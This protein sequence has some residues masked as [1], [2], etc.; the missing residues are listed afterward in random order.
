LQREDLNPVEEAMAYQ[1]L[2][3]DFQLTQESIA[4]KV[5]KSRAAVA[6]SLRLLDL[7]PEVREWLAGGRLSVGHAKVLLGVKDG[8]EQNFLANQILRQ[9]LTVRET[10]KLVTRHLQA[11]ENPASPPGKTPGSP[12]TLPPAL[13][14]VR[15]RIR[16]H[17]GTEVNIQHNPK[18]GKIEIAYYGNDDL[19]RIL[20]L[21]KI[22]VD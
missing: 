16:T 22:N 20:Q 7:E 15:N 19:D 2:A 11:K 6:N 18:K 4:R 10:E 14:N 9:G 1:K 17:L 13:Q 8:E 3:R 12:K 21:L 5:G